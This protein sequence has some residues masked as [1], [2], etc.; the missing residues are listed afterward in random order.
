MFLL[1][2]SVCM[3]H[4]YI[5]DGDDP[6]S[7]WYTGQGVSFMV[8]SVGEK[9]NQEPKRGNKALRNSM[10]FGLPIRVVKRL[11]DKLFVYDGLWDV[12][13]MRQVSQVTY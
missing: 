1:Q 13:A 5:G 9:K 11:C 4:R 7:Q 10:H 2:F 12:L 6:H 3:A 8:T